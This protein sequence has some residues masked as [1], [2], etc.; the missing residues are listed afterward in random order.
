MVKDGIHAV[1]KSDLEHRE[2]I[3][4][5]MAETAHDHKEAPMIQGKWPAEPLLGIGILQESEP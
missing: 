4:V 2:R 3:C 1:H 5:M